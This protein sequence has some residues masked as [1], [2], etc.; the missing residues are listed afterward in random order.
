VR[1]AIINGST[2]LNAAHDVIMFITDSPQAWAD[3]PDGI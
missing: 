3:L 2:A 1:G